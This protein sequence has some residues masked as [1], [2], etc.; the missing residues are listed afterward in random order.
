MP[1]P[2]RS[3]AATGLVLATFACSLAACAGPAGEAADLVLTHGKIVTVDDALP[4]AQALAVKDG[5]ILAVGSDAEIESHVGRD[6][7]VI[8]LQGQLAIPG[9]IDSHLHFMGVGEAQLQLNLMEVAGWDEIVDM[10]ARAVAEAG[11]GTLIRGRGWHQ[12]KWDRVPEPNVEGFPLHTSLSAVSPDN[13]VILVHASGHA[14]FANARAMEMAGITATTPDPPGGEILRDAQ[15]NPLGVFREEADALLNPAREAATPEDPR[16][17]ATLAAQELLAKGITT[18]HDAGV[19]FETVDLYRAMIDAG[20]MGVRLNVWLGASNEELRERID[21]YRLI[22]YGDDHLT[23]RTIKRLADG[24]LGSR[25][26]WLLE[27]YAD[28]SGHTGLNTTPMDVIEE[29]ARIAAEH[30][31]QLAVHA[32]GD[33]ANREVLDVFQRTFEAFP[34]ITDWRWRNEHTQHLDPADIPRMGALGVIASMQAIHCTSDAPY[35]LQRLG[36]QRTAEGAYVWRKLM[37]GGAIIANGTDAPVEMVD[38]LPGFY[39]LVT[40]RLKDGS[41]FHPDQVL[42]RAEALRAYTLNGAYAGFEE[43][44]KG[45]LTP[46]KLADITVLSKDILTIPEDEIPSTEVST[47]IVGGKVVY[48][49]RT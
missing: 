23:V 3:S 11:P 31:F 13:P 29:T 9:L 4:E 34:R 30:G 38:P 21:Q 37:D 19:G 27:P 39:A 24:A 15:G 10:V 33:R 22:G 7:E 17:V 47:T 2:A 1:V 35:V 25:G 41:T 42:S 40:R 46:G 28:L 36:P 45:S 20:E 18:V 26:A 16:R 6:T 5:R 14:T 12:E 43:G 44:V 49:G 8:D 32:I 48:K